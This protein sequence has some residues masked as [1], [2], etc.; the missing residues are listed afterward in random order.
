MGKQTKL[1]LYEFQRTLYEKAVE[2]ASTHAPLDAPSVIKYSK[3]FYRTLPKSFRT[4]DLS[5][6]IKDLQNT[7]VMLF[8]DFHTH[9]QAQK[10]LIRILESYI[11]QSPDRQIVIAMEMF[12]AVDQE[13]INNYLQGEIEEEELLKLCEYEQYWG[14]PWENYRVI[15]KFALDYN[16][17]I[18][19]INTDFAGKDSLLKR[20]KFAASIL[21]EIKQQQPDSLCACIIGEYHLADSHLPAQISPEIQTLRILT[22]IDEFYFNRDNY[23]E[24]SSTEYLSL[25][26]SL[27]CILNSPPWIKWRSYSMWEEMKASELD[28]D[29][30]L[31]YTEESFDIDYQIVSIIG[32][33]TEFLGLSI[34]ESEIANFHAYCDLDNKD[35]DILH[36]NESVSPYTKSM[37]EQR[38]KIDGLFYIPEVKYALLESQSLNNLSDLAGQIL[39]SVLHKYNN[40]D[41]VENH[42]FHRVVMVSAGVLASKTLNP[43]RKCPDI[44]SFENE[45]G[46]LY[47]KKLSEGDKVYRESLRYLV[48]FYYKLLNGK[49]RIDRSIIHRDTQCN[50]IYSLMIGQLL[51]IESYNAIMNP[52]KSHINFND[53][54]QFSQHIKDPKQ[55]FSSLIEFIFHT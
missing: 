3:E 6:I 7:D 37:M 21:N 32:H 33:L 43:R 26:P 20:D 44:H 2:E 8:G 49:Y 45:L 38:L 53:V 28:D 9:R 34:T 25:K 23:D 31:L 17:Q 40:K 52:K 14:F 13:H 41:V 12:R 10:G 1:R 16:I 19:G 48:K 39:F 22:N 30:A 4:T 42:F 24:Y 18:I 11:H 51:G 50:G 35:L 46:R 54:F 29:P 27:Y 15:I 55:I 47:R 5:H 36:E